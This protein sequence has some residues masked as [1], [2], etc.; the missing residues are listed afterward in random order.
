M[1][2]KGK[3][4]AGGGNMS[5]ITGRVVYTGS[6]IDYQEGSVVSRSVIDKESGTVTLFAFDSGQGL[7]EHTAPFDAIVEVVDGEAEVT[8]SGKE[9]TVRKGQMI[10]MPAGEPHSLRAPDKFKMLLIMIKR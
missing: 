6:I 4:Y 1:N 3:A 9:H 8:I 2:R 7:S 10:I 5:D